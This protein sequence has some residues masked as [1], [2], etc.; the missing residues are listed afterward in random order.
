MMSGKWQVSRDG[1]F[2]RQDSGD[3]VVMALGLDEGGYGAGA[4]LRGV[5]G[6]RAFHVLE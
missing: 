1:A 4:A 6:R 5:E 3:G 2:H